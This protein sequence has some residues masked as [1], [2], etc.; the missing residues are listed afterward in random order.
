M[1]AP[2]AA[3]AWGFYWYGDLWTT[4]MV[5]AFFAFL[6][7]SVSPD[8]AKRLY[9]P[10]GVGGVLGGVAGATGVAALLTGSTR[11]HGS[12]LCAAATLLIAALQRPP[13]GADRAGA[14]RPAPAARREPARPA[15]CGPS[16]ARVTCSLSS[17]SS[18]CY[19]IASTL[20]DFQ[21]TRRVA[22]RS[23]EA[24]IDRP[25][26]PSSPSRTPPLSRSRSWRRRWC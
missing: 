6:N 18:R 19:E 10:I 9:G 25:L 20:L 7:D 16:R 14:D 17:R 12:A 13:G 8:E 4:L 15:P 21:F 3:A 2:G 23:T 5:V 22:H 1:R 26:A 11:A 24:A